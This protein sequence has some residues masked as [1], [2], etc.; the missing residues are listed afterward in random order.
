MKFLL[1]TIYLYMVLYIKLIIKCNNR[2]KY[3]T[4]NRPTISVSIRSSKNRKPISSER[5]EFPWGSLAGQYFADTRF[6][7]VYRIDRRTAN[8]WGEWSSYPADKGTA[9]INYDATLQGKSP[10]RET[11]YIRLRS[12]PPTSFPSSPAPSSSIPHLTLGSYFH[13]WHPTLSPRS[14]FAGDDPPLRPPG[15]REG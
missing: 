11:S 1:R 13:P 7:A 2:I 12:L 15:P 10:V 9:S 3:G 14:S 4:E 8:V 6:V 5:H